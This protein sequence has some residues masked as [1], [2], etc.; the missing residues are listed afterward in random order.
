MRPVL[1]SSSHIQPTLTSPP[2]HVWLSRMHAC[3]SSLQKA[4]SNNKRNFTFIFDQR[5]EIETKLVVAKSAA[6]NTL[7][8]FFYSLSFRSSLSQYTASFSLVLLSRAQLALPKM[9]PI[10]YMIPVICITSFYMIKR[11]LIPFIFSLYI[12]IV[13]TYIVP[14][15]PPSS[16]PPI[17]HFQP[18]PPLQPSLQPPLLEHK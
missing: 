16:F 12:Y 2:S 8:R 14:P 9:A 18:H 15:D 7:I 3:F 6:F 13:H 11:H 4:E 5:R 17:H 10:F 1:S